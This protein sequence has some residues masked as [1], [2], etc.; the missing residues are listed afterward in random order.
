MRVV[1]R[2][3]HI[4]S[5]PPG[6]R[7]QSRLLSEY[8]VE[9]KLENLSYMA[10]RWAMGGW[11]AVAKAQAAGKLLGVKQLE[12]N[13]GRPVLLFASEWKLQTVLSELNEL[14]QLRPY[15]VAPDVEEKRR[16]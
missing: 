2:H 7:A 15:A 1:P 12:D 5:S 10:A 13:W 16:K 4:P 9:V 11:E 3:A 8:G 14:L 6:L